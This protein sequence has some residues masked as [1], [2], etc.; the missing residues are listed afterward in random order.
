MGWKYNFG[1]IVGIVIGV[2]V[3]M[4]VVNYAIYSLKGKPQHIE[5][6]DA[7]AYNAPPQQNVGV[8]DEVVANVRVSPRS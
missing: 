6:Y 5:Q 4:G 1:Q 7:N 2:T 3:G 8:F